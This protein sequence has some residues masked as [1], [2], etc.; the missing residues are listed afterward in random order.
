[1]SAD[2]IR[3]VLERAAGDATGNPTEAGQAYAALS[4]FDELIAA[5]KEVDLQARRKAG[6][7]WWMIPNMTINQL[8]A[9]LAKVPA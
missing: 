7:G 2:K 6:G 8:R 5:L 9:V 4:Y 3:A 1:M